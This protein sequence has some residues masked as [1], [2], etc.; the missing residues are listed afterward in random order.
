MK[1]YLK[2]LMEREAREVMGRGG[3]NL[4][5]LTLV[6]VATF[7]SIAFSEGSKIYLEDR[8]AD[9]FTNWVSIKKATDNERFNNFRD[10]LYLEENKKKFDYANVLMDQYNNYNI[11]RHNGG[12]LY[13]SA[14]FFADVKSK[15]F[16]AIL[17][18]NNIVNGC[19]VDTAVV[20]NNTMGFVITLDAVRRL[21]YAADSLPAYIEYF[22]GISDEAL[23]DKNLDSLG[24]NLYDGKF[25]R[26]ALPVLAVVRRLPNNVDMMS[27]NYFYEQHHYAFTKPFDVVSHEQQYLHHLI[28]WVNQEIGVVQFENYVKSIV[29]DSLKGVVQVFQSDDTYRAMK[30][31]KPGIMCEVKL[32]DERMPVQVFNQ[33]DGAIARQYTTYQVCRVYDMEY[34]NHPSPRSDFLSVEFN[35]LDHISEFEAFAKEHKIDL[36]MENVHSKQNFNAV[37][38]MAQVLTI[39]MVIFSI[40]C[41]I[42]FMVNMLQSYFQKVKRNIGTFKAFGMNGRELIQ[43]YVIILVAIVSAGV[44]LALLITWAVQGL[45]PVL[46]I[47]KDGF[48]YLSLWNETT[49][50]ATAVIFVSTI[51][52]VMWVM[53]RLLSQTPGDLIYDRN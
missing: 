29:P 39:A 40:V 33:V 46:G 34:E 4:W 32:G 26:I 12:V 44:L 45:L 30:P 38:K 42:M 48:N 1:Q 10:S 49:Y 27:A 41:I 23:V 19:Q 53:T 24:L 5:L 18:E 6:L 9:P 13:L 50:V 8:M 15:L 47:E 2:L 20:Q 14:R 28:Y 43:V 52:T 7:I 17:D 21:G 11:S 22:H 25:C 3:Q 31:W 37:S 16:G 35:S 51:V 36:E